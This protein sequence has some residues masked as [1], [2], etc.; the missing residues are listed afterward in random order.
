MAGAFIGKILW[1]D[2]SEGKW[3]DEELDEEIY[4]NFLGG[5][6]LGAKIVY[7]RQPA[8]VDPLS[9]EAIFGIVP[10]ILTGTGAM[11]MGRYLAV[12]KSPLTGGWGDANSGGYFSPAIKKA[13]YDGIFFK[14]KS[15]KPVYLAIANN[16]IELRDATDLWGVDAVETEKR[17]KELFS[18]EG[19]KRVDVAAIGQAGENLSRISGI[20]TDRGRIAAR[21][22]F[23]AVMGSKNL[24][25]LVLSGKTKIPIAKRKE[26]TEVTRK[27]MKDFEGVSNLFNHAWLGK[28]L[29]F[30]GKVLSKRLPFLMKNEGF[31]WKAILKR[32]GTA[33]LTAFSGLS[34]DS[35]VKN[36]NG[37]GAIDF[38]LPK[39]KKISDDSVI[40]LETE[41]YNCYSCP[42]GCGGIFKLNPEKYGYDETHKPEYET[43]GAFGTLILNDDLDIIVK[44]NE[45][46]NRAGIDTISAGE[47]I[48]FAFE[49]YERGI[50]TKEDTG[51]LELTWG[52]GNAAMELVKKMINREGIGE[53]FADGIKKAVEKLGKPETAEFGVHAGGTELPMHDPRFDPGYGIAYEAE[54]TPGR[55]T[56]VSYTYQE[57][58]SLSKRHKD[59][60][61]QSSLYSTKKKYSTEDKA[62]GQYYG[63]LWQEL[64][65]TCGG[66][67]FGL[68]VGVDLPLVDWLNASTGWNMSEEEYLTT[69]RRIKTLRQAFNA[70]EGIVPGRDFRMTGR[71]KGHPPLDKGPLRGVDLDMDKLTGD[72]WNELGWDYETGIPKKET[73]KELGLEKVAEDIYK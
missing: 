53:T 66:C 19:I 7:D 29:G 52:N 46:C 70:R 54:P 59:L 26:M 60:P 16:K 17:L 8:G 21:Q 18:K 13:G 64:N 33:G 49:L 48:A 23:G 51:G 22:G 34:G 10:G 44:I 15:E 35:P 38:P 55:H 56:I 41:K 57:L 1:V 20:V 28:V 30:L 61:K 27:Y 58:M 72:F 40:A 68:Q 2:L 25:A 5:Y 39:V 31:Q 42:V 24:K 73:L 71:A 43:L 36:W 69:A 47:T 50:I 9:P 45:I 67:L 4:K 3:W 32:Y 65:A 12:G 62:R 11:F 37:V 63:S 6:G 14:G